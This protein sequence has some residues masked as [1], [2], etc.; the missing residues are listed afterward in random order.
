MVLAKKFVL[1]LL[2]LVTAAILDSGPNPIFQFWNLESDHASIGIWEQ[3]V[4]WL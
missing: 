1:F 2:F 3:L 4:W